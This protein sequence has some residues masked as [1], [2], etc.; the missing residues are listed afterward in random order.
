MDRFLNSHRLPHPHTNTLGTAPLQRSCEPA[1]PSHGRRG[2]DG[3]PISGLRPVAAIVTRRAPLARHPPAKI[4]RRQPLASSRAIPN[5]SRKSKRSVISHAIHRHWL[6]WGLL[7]LAPTSVPDAG[8]PLQRLQRSPP[9][10]SSQPGLLPS[11]TLLCRQSPVFLARQ[12]DPHTCHGCEAVLALLRR[13]KC[14]ST[15]TILV[16]GPSSR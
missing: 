1:D 13:L 10:W 14:L 2:G 15:G 7:A 6:P 11:P 4:R 16:R 3:R 5:R 8:N 12:L 9:L